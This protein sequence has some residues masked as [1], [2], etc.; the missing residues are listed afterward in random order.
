MN[1]IKTLAVAVLGTCLMVSAPVSG[2]AFEPWIQLKASYQTSFTYD[3]EEVAAFGIDRARAGAAG[4]FAEQFYFE[5]VFEGK[6]TERGDGARLR[7][8]FMSWEFLERHHASIGA[9]E[10]A[11]SRP[12]SGTEFNFI[13]Y[14]I[15]SSP[16]S[17]QYGFMVEGSLMN[18]LISYSAA[19]CNGE[20]LTSGNIG[21]GF[22][23]LL[24]AEL[25][26]MGK[27]DLRD[28]AAVAARDGMFNISLAAALDN[29][30]ETTDSGVT[31]EYYDAYYFL[32]DFT[33]KVDYIS[34]F[35]QAHFN[36]FTRKEDGTYWG[37]EEGNVRKAMGGFVQVA[38]NFKGITG[39]ALEPIVKYEFWRNT[40]NEGLSDLDVDKQQL[41]VGFTYYVKQHNLK[42]NLEYR[43]VLKDDKV[44]FVKEPSDQF[45]GF[46]ITHKFASGKVGL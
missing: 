4:K 45:V 33:Y 46:R 22:L 9:I 29:K 19:V 14:D 8:A 7:K 31:Y 41:A 12:I 13:N 35:A 16:D 25:L 18:N 42:L 30:A 28:G 32:A 5:V 20:G 10:I 17:Y 2:A 1:T 37:G 15:T 23:Y 26:L 11:F 44:Y 39:I 6:Y 21:R 40:V 38:Y 36:M 34:I 27:K 43:K 3:L 24:R